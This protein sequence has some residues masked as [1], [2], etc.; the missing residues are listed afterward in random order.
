[1]SLPGG[2]RQHFDFLIAIFTLN[3][4]STSVLNVGESGMVGRL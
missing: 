1:M 3:I 2:F 4:R